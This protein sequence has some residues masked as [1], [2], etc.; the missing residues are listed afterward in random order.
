VKEPYI[1]WPQALCERTHSAPSRFRIEPT[2]LG[3]LRFIREWQKDDG[4]WHDDGEGANIYVPPEL[5]GSV[6]QALLEADA[7]Y[8][9]Y[10]K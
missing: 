10:K 7:W 1:I 6:G 5:L 8:R 2:L 4:T 3:G 9:K